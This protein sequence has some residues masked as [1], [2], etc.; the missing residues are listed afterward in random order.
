[1][2]NEE[3]LKE[4]ADAKAKLEY[5]H[6]MGIRFGM[7]KTTDRPE[8]YLAHTWMENSTFNRMFEEWTDSIGW[9][10][11]VAKLEAELASSRQFWQDSVRDALRDKDQ[12]IAR[13][14][15]DLRIE[16]EISSWNYNLARVKAEE[17]NT[18]HAK[19]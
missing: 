12:A 8:P 16:K 6:G 11:R 4:L 2:E 14:V 9:E 13:L 7:M 3:L 15:E 18:T 19:I 5:V 10:T 1:M 17:N